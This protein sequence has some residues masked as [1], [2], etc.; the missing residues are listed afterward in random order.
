MKILII[1][2]IIALLAFGAWFFFFKE[3]NIE[4]KDIFPAKYYNRAECSKACLS[5][6]CSVSGCDSGLSECDRYCE[7][8]YK[9]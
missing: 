8:N 2:I 6:Y 9:E 3:K 5:K 7:E 4:N 1:I